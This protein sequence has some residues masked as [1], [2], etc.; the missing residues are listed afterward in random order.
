MRKFPGVLALIFG[1]V[2]GVVA[3][4]GSVESTRDRVLGDAGYQ[5][6]LPRAGHQTDQQAGSHDSR[7]A[8]RPGATGWQRARRLHQNP[9]GGVF[10]HIASA[11]LWVLVGVG[12]LVLIS[13]LAQEYR[14]QRDGPAQAG[15]EPD[16]DAQ[17]RA[18]V[19]ARPL[20]DAE[21]LARQGRFDAAIHVLLLRTI[22]SLKR[23]LPAGL[24]RSL[25]SREILARVPMNDSA[26]AAIAELVRA[27]ERSY[28]GS[29]VPGSAEYQACRA[30]F[31][32]FAEAYL[33]RAA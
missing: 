19:V 2:L 20:D 18:A 14:G 30:H 13:W 3:A 1:V 11:L 23:T 7:R 24:P 28:F 16:D 15:A 6:E 31:Q 10:G 12:V 5:T 21:V 4:P 29:E 8:L 32:R 22:E 17:A 27:V 33:Q 9:P 25:T 26:R